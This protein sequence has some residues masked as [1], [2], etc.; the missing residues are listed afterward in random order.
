MLVAVVRVHHHVTFGVLTEYHIG[1]EDAAQLAQEAEG[2]I[3]EVF[4]RNVDHQNQLAH[5]Q[6]LWHVSAVEA[7]PFALGVVAALITVAVSIVVFAVLVI[8]RA[9]AENEK[10]FN[11]KK[12]C[13]WYHKKLKKQ[14]TGEKK[15][16]YN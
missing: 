9:E 11:Q 2:V 3:Q 7:V 13:V 16:V 4:R 1:A 14:K 12:F 5:S 6:F 8:Q 15:T 10:I